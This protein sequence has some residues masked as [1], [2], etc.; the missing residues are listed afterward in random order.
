[1]FKYSKDMYLETI[2][3]RIDKQLTMYL[4]VKN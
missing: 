4:S 3:S 1:M 2:A